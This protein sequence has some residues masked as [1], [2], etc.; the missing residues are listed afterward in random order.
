M[1]WQEPFPILPF[2]FLGFHS[3]QRITSS[4]FRGLG[5]SKRPMYFIA[6]ACVVNIG[7]D[8]LLMGALHM[9]SIGAAL[10]TTLSQAVSVLVALLVIRKQKI[11]VSV[12]KADFKLKR[13]VM[14]QIVKIGI[15]IALQ[16]G[17]IQ[18]A[19]L[20]ITVIANQRGLHDAAAVGIVEKVISFLCLLRCCLRYR[21][22]VPRTSVPENRNEQCRLCG[23]RC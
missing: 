3:L 17:L 22:W 18:V 12:C 5:D 9:G 11:G 15:P 2:A 7:L 8:Y 20:V 16:D 21:H 19:F 23:M 14:G 4:V 6:I 13:P 10:G 1:L